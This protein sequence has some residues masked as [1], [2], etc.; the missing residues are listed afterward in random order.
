MRNITRFFDIANQ[1]LRLNFKDRNIREN[2]RRES[3]ELR[4]N[5]INSEYLEEE[6]QNWIDLVDRIEEVYSESKDKTS[7]RIRQSNIRL[8]FII[9]DILKDENNEDELDISFSQIKTFIESK[10]NEAI[11]KIKLRPTSL[12]IEELRSVFSD[13]ELPNKFEVLE[14]NDLIVSLKEERFVNSLQHSKC[15]LY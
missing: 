8:K 12:F 13:G 15:Y 11:K 7:E 4:K 3:F 6:L 1:E 9:K 5:L 2:F 10:F 14:F